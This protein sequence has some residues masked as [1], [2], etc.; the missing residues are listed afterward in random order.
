MIRFHSFILYAPATV[1]PSVIESPR[2]MIFIVDGFVVV[3]EIV[4]EGIME[5]VVCIEG[6]IVVV[7]VDGDG[8]IVDDGETTVDVV[9]IFDT[10]FKIV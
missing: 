8:V 5:V 3:V 6:D 2:G 4:G 10:L 9:G 7:F 1:K